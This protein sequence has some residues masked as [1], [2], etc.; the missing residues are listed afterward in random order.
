MA[1]NFD[2]TIPYLKRDPLYK[3]IKPF[4]ASFRVENVTEEQSSNHIFEYKPMIIYDSR[5]VQE[6]FELDFNGFCFM[7]NPTFMTSELA[8]NVAEHQDLY[9]K[10]VEEFLYKAFPQYLRFECMD[11]QVQPFQS[12]VYRDRPNV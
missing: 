1:Q 11:L 2:S 3:K 6:P 9:F 4:S 5:D 12:C 7:K 8:D 10:E